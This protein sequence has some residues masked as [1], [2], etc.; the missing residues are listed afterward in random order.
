MNEERGLERTQDHKGH[1]ASDGRAW[2]STLIPGALMCTVNFCAMLALW[3]EPG[4]K[5]LRSCSQVLRLIRKD[6][7]SKGVG[8]GEGVGTSIL[9]NGVK[10]GVRSWHPGAAARAVPVL[11]HL[12]PCWPCKAGS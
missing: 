9:S 10:L 1:T 6:A 11:P 8:G 5:T 3:G 7:G 12:I 4:R 2:I